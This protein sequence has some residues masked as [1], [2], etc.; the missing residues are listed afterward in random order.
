MQFRFNTALVEGKLSMVPEALYDL[1]GPQT[2]IFLA[3][4]FIKRSINIFYYDIDIIENMLIVNM[5]YS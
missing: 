3:S 5:K 1:Y 2:L 4:S